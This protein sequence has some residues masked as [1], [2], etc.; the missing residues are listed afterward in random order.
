MP[1]RE[2]ISFYNPETKS[3]ITVHVAE[4]N[5]LPAM[6]GYWHTETNVLLLGADRWAEWQ[7]LSGDLVKRGRFLEK[8]QQPLL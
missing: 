4:S 5:Q 6:A 7:T 3:V 2:H 8:V 1:M